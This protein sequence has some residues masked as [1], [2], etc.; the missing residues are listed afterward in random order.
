M[1]AT[2]ICPHAN[3]RLSRGGEQFL[4]SNIKVIHLRF[5]CEGCGQHFRAIGVHDGISIDAPSTKD[6]GSTVMIPI[7]PVGEEPDHTGRMI[8]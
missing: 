5:V 7:V 8:A 3:M 4:D 2:H 6:N 1:S